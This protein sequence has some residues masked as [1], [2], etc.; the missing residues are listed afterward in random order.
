MINTFGLAFRAG[1]VDISRAKEYFQSR[2]F[3]CRHSNPEEYEDMGRIHVFKT[4]TGE[5]ATESNYFFEDMKAYTRWL[6]EAGV[7][8]RDENIVIHH[9]H[10]DEG[11]FT[12]YKAE[13]ED[14]LT[15]L[16]KVKLIDTIDLSAKEICSFLEWGA[17]KDKGGSFNLTDL[18]YCYYQN[19]E[20]FDLLELIDTDDEIP[21]K[22]MT[23][24][25]LGC[26]AVM[27]FNRWFSGYEK[28][29]HAN[30]FAVEALMKELRS[31]SYC[32]QVKV[33]TGS[34]VHAKRKYGLRKKY[35]SYLPYLPYQHK[36]KDKVRILKELLFTLI[37]AY[38]SDSQLP[39]YHHSGEDRIMVLSIDNDYSYSLSL[40]KQ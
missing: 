25:N 8:D 9:R 24:H 19:L 33:T 21:F 32:G 13:S 31:S 37:H 34:Y 35:E 7:L 23:Y 5:T 4:I 1:K 30:D 2:G 6:I 17:P 18:G 40:Y 14:D 16:Y 10:N 39:F 29:K 3:T 20:T 28:F 26:H 22:T 27:L 38:T 11:M 36:P 12:V 15:K